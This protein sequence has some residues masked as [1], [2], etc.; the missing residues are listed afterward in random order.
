MEAAKQSF[1]VIVWVNKVFYFPQDAMS[2]YFS[3]FTIGLFI[4]ILGCYVESG[5]LPLVKKLSAIPNNN[6][7]IVADSESV[8]VYFI[9]NYLQG[10][11]IAKQ[12][13]RL[14]LIF[15]MLPNSDVSQRMMET[16]FG[17]K[18]IKR[19]SNRFVCIKVDGS[20]ETE[21]CKSI[22]INGFPTILFMN[23]N[24][25]ELQRLTGKLT[26]DRLAVQMHLMLQTAAVTNGMINRK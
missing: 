22:N 16:I 7:N 5:S 26:P 2:R 19:L 24:G 6:D 14:I 9:E 17:D 10:L 1:F 15:F 18:E 25:E 12:D 20:Q 8:P 3:I 13:S 23:P 4:G 21:F 11:K